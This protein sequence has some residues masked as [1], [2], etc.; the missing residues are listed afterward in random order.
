VTVDGLGYL[1]PGGMP[2][3]TQDDAELATWIGFLGEL[4]SQGWELPDGET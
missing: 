1:S 2:P 4:M 3:L